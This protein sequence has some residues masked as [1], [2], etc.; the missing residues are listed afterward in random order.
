MNYYLVGGIVLVIIIVL[1][2]LYFLLKEQTT[3]AT[4]PE[5][6]PATTP[7]TT[8]A[9]TPETTPTTTP[10]TTPATTPETTPT[11]AP[12]T[13]PA[14]APETTPAT[15]PETTP[16]TAPETTPTTTPETTPATTPETTPTTAPETTPATALETTP[17]TTPET[18]PATTP[19]TT[20]DPTQLPSSF[21]NL[22]ETYASSRI[23]GFDNASSETLLGPSKEA[24]E[25]IDLLMENLPNSLKEKI[26]CSDIKT[27]NSKLHS[28]ISCLTGQMYTWWVS[29]DNIDIDKIRQLFMILIW[30]Q[31]MSKY[32]LSYISD[33]MVYNKE[34]KTVV[35]NLPE[36][37]AE[38]TCN[39]K[40]ISIDSFGAA[41]KQ[42]MAIFSNP[43]ESCGCEYQIQTVDISSIC[44]NVNWY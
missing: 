12:E 9:T 10:E 37:E 11:T 31:Y 3:P 20:P 42:Y 41:F 18:T 34:K 29:G 21:E 30:L 8:P 13:T 19:E 43:T 22:L 28:V 40:I 16:A 4:T 26:S 38:L 5:T 14:I 39:N 27:Q 35:I 6:T 25:L 32:N 1:F 7:E 33:V 36:L 2:M 44:N 17:A 15:T 23:E 24:L